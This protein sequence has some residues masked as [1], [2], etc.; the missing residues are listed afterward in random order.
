MSDP[1]TNRRSLFRLRFPIA[2]Q[3]ELST[4]IHEYQV[5]ELAEN[6]A[7]L[8]ANGSVIPSESWT[9]AVLRLGSGNQITTA[10]KLSR[11]DENHLVVFLHQNIPHKEMMSE[12]QRLIAKYGKPKSQNNWN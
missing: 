11:I 7:R 12:Q 6:S 9:P 10:V 8:E 4:D 3:P 1:E 5:V 2:E